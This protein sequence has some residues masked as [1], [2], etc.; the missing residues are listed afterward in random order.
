MTI[1][2]GFLVETLEGAE[3]VYATNTDELIYNIN[4]ESPNEI[5]SIYQIPID[6]SYLELDIV[7]DSNKWKTYFSKINW[8]E[9]KSINDKKNSDW[10]YKFKSENIKNKL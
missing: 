1:P 2:L 10:W 3:I 4:R 9:L 8:G 5:L 7:K 6:G